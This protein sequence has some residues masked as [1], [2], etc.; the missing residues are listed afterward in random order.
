[1]IVAL[2]SKFQQ[3]TSSRLY[4]AYLIAT[5]IKR[6]LMSSDEHLGKVSTKLVQNSRLCLMA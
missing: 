1:M 4:Q 6:L 5:I 2:I 3:L